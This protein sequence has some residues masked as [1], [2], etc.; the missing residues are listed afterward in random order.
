M[1]GWFGAKK[2]SD[3][4]RPPITSGLPPKPA[5]PDGYW[6]FTRDF[7][8]EISA[9][10]LRAELEKGAPTLADYLA[11]ISAKLKAPMSGDQAL[12]ERAARFAS[13]WSAGHRLGP[14]P[15]ITV[16]ADHSGSLKGMRSEIVARVLIALNA[17]FEGEAI[18]FEVLGFTTS[19]WQGGNSRRRWMRDYVGHIY[20]GRLCDILHIVYRDAASPLPGWAD[21]LVLATSNEVLKE[22]IDGEAILWAAERAERFAPSTWICICVTDGAPLDDSTIEANTPWFLPNHLDQVVRR[23]EADKDARIG[24]LMLAPVEESEFALPYRVMQECGDKPDQAPALVF[25]LLEA[26]VWPKATVDMGQGR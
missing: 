22:N 8:R 4:M 21:D 9:R 18:D 23:I 1:F 17:A 10:D 16:L 24:C 26:L 2:R 25:D 15:L 13:R 14:R 6:I 5:M 11:E 12:A 3:A 7:D 19:S 20:P